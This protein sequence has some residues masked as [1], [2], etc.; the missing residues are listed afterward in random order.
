MVMGIEP[1]T[2][3]E[4]RSIHFE[5]GDFL[6]LY[7]DGLT[8]AID[9]SGEPFGTQRLERILSE[10]R[11][12]SAAEIIGQVEEAVFAHSVDTTPFDDITMLLVRR[13]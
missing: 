4:Q 8:D 13:Q 10:T 9:A 5:P 6:L 12:A 3:Y 11:G 7:T 2:P 1:E